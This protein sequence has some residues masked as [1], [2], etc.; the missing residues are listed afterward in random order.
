MDGKSV[1][2]NPFEQFFH[3]QLVC[4]SIL[5][6]LQEQVNTLQK[7]VIAKSGD[8][9]MNLTELRRYHPDHPAEA[10]VYEWVSKRIIPVYKKGK[11]LYFLKSEIDQW[12]KEGRKKTAQEITESADQIIRRRYTKKAA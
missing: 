7:Q 2:V 11:K 4:K 10:T 8:T 5:L 1:V 6:S 12:L 9:W 3:E